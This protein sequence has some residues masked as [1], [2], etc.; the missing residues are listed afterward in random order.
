MPSSTTYIGWGSTAWGQGSWGTDLIIVEVDGVQATGA[1]G[2][3][4]LSL[5]CTVFPTGVST[6]G[7]VGTVSVSGAATVQP[8]GIEATGSVG[9]VSVVAEANVFPSGIEATGET[10]TVAIVENEGNVRLTTSLPP[11]HVAVMGIERIIPS[12]QDLDLFLKVLVQSA[13]GQKLSSYVSML[14]GSS[15]PEGAEEIHLVLVDNGR[16]RILADPILRESLHCIR[17]GACLNVCPVYQKLGGHAYGW[18]YSVDIKC[19]FNL[20]VACRFN[21]FSA[22]LALRLKPV[23]SISVIVKAMERHKFFFIISSVG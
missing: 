17:C 18:V 14:T 4:D 1:V 20:F 8:S 19:E 9:T 10:G 3:V 15:S 22:L 13:T 23:R 16:T 7:A 2:T 21:T 11:V 12:L 5:G 6:T